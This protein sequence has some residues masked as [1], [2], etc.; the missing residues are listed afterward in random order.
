VIAVPTVPAYGVGQPAWLQPAVGTSVVG[1]AGI[2]ILRLMP[3]VVFVTVAVPP[4]VGV[5]VIVLN[6]ESE[7]GVALTPV[8]VQ[9]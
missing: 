1:G 9:L 5:K 6:P 8:T 3:R 4:D 2:V 7:D